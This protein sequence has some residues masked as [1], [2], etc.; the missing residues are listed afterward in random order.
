MSAGGAGGVLGNDD[1]PPNCATGSSLIRAG[2]RDSLHRPGYRSGHSRAEAAGCLGSAARRVRQKWLARSP[3]RVGAASLPRRAATLTAASD[4]K[5]SS[6]RS[7]CGSPRPRRKLCMAAR[8]KRRSI[9]SHRA[10]QGDTWSRLSPIHQAT[11]RPPP[12]S[13]SPTCPTAMCTSGPTA[14]Q[15]PALHRFVSPTSG[16][17]QLQL[18]CPLSR[19]TS[20]GLSTPPTTAGPCG[21]RRCT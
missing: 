18:V 17:S 2:G 19:L 4:T 5:K 21:A 10:P 11:R 6:R 16:A 20:S 8:G 12:L 1:E 13:A 3:R 14:G 9:Q 7:W 15:L